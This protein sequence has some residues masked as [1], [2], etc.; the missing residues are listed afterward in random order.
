MSGHYFVY[1]L[2]CADGTYY[3]GSTNNLEKRFEAHNCGRGA[4]YTMARRPV[5]LV[6]FKDCSTRREAM[7]R[8]RQL[9]RLPASEKMRLAHKTV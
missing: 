3:T 8:E 7:R 1:M 4:R 6:W 9:K 2:E 5:S